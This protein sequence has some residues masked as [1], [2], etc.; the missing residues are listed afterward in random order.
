MFHRFRY[1]VPLYYTPYVPATVDNLCYE[2]S[3]HECIVYLEVLVPAGET[4][5]LDWTA[6]ADFGTYNGGAD[7]NGDYI[8]D[9]ADLGLLYTAWGF[10]VYWKKLMTLKLS[11][12]YIFWVPIVE[13]C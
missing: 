12:S 5:V 6:Y 4:V 10:E 3:L 7:F 1:S 2:T 9:S 8:V 11:K 13:N